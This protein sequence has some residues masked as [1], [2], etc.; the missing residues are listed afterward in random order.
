MD[1]DT[2]IVER[3]GLL[4]SISSS[5]C[6][7]QRPAGR[8]E[9]SR[10]ALR[11]GDD[12]AGLGEPRARE[13]VGEPHAVDDQVSTERLGDLATASG[14]GPENSAVSLAQRG[15]VHRGSPSIPPLPG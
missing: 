5:R 12:Q 7:E 4:I 14:D 11:T 3:A 15:G 8:G 1:S 9:S 10:T 6:L 13:L 2:S